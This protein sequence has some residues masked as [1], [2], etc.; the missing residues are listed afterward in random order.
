M[1]VLLSGGEPVFRTLSVAFGVR[2]VLVSC[3]LS[4]CDLGVLS[5]CGMLFVLLRLRRSL[6]RGVWACALLCGM[7]F[8]L[9]FV[10]FCLC[11]FVGG[12]VVRVVLVGSVVFC[13]RMPFLVVLLAVFCVLALVHCWFYVSWCFVVMVGVVLALFRKRNYTSCMR[14][15]VSQTT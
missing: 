13:V 6:R 8:C 3:A 9:L 7:L 14:L 5:L 1:V 11:V 12:G 2:S 4:V 15:S 10:L